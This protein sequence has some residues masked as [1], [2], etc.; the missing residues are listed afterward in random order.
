MEVLLKDKIPSYI[1][2]EEYERNQ[3]QL[4]MNS[5]KGIGVPKQGKSLLSSL[6]I[7]GRCGLK[8][9]VQYS[10][11]GA[12]LRYSC[13]RMAVDYGEKKCQSLSG[14]TLDKLV[15]KKVLEAIQ[16]SAL[17]ISLQVAKK[18]EQERKQNLKH[19]QQRLER[20]SYE[21]ERA[22]RQY[23]SVEPENRL[24]VRTLEKKWEEALS[25]ETRLKGEYERYL[26]EQPIV[27]T[28]A[29]R[30]EVRALASDIPMLWNS[31]TTTQE[32]R[33][34]IVR[35]LIERVIVTVQGNTEKVH[36]EIH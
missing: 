5:S 13:H 27:L 12:K 10:D 35:L 21:T 7:C 36:V 8:M 19:W 3:R 25:S 32:Q 31:T 11:N 20:A 23:N 14:N 16:P 4:L 17:E 29:E 9:M 28:E 30:N 18:F 33:K 2:W 22:Y 26:T 6:I 1:S 34:S 24:V 15:E